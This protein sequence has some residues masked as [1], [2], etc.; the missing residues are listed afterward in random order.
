[1]DTNK[2]PRTIR[3]ILEYRRKA[4]VEFMLSKIVNTGKMKVIDIGCGID[5]RSF[6]DF[7][8]SDFRITGVDIIP[9]ERVQHRHAHFTYVQ[10]DAQD[11]S[12]F[13]DDEVDLAVS[14]GMLEHITEELAFNRIVHEIQRVAHQHIVVVPYKYCWIEPHYGIPFFPIWPYSIKLFMVKFF[15]LSDH[16]SYVVQ[17]VDYIRN[18]YRWLSNSEYRIVFPD[19]TIFL[20]P[21]LETIAITK[22][23]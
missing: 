6:A 2:L 18:N 5:G 22:S 4:R 15:N 3:K 11:L 12:C 13:E 8:P 9:A 16:R 1:M 19:S 20:L 17:D 10:R 7:V 21:T 23:S 14:I